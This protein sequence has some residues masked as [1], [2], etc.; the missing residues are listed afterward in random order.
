M[1]FINYK[2][3]IPVCV[4]IGVAVLV[5]VLLMRNQD[6]VAAN[7]EASF[8][9]EIS[10]TEETTPT[11]ETISAVGSDNPLE[12]DKYDPVNELVITYLNALADGDVDTIASITNNM[13]DI[14]R[15]RIAELGKC[16]EAFPEYNVFTKIGPVEGSY[17]VYAAARA[18]F[19]KVDVLVPGIYCFYVCV[20]EAGNY[21][22]N[23]GTLTEEEQIYIDA[24]NA[25]E[26]VVNLMQAIDTEY[27][28]LLEEN[29]QVRKY[30]EVMQNE[31]RGAVGTALASQSS[32][33]AE[34]TETGED[35]TVLKAE[36]QA[37][38]TD[39][40]NVRSSDSETADKLGS[41]VK[42]TTIDVIEIRVNGWAK[43][44]YEGKEAYIK[45]DYLQV[46]EEPAEASESG[47]TA[48]GTAVAKETVN[49]RAEA[50]TTA[51]RMGQIYQGTK[52][53]WVEDL[54]NGWSK[55]IYE[56]KV[57]YIKSE[58]LKKD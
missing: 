55:I 12:A 48:K 1:K 24:V 2:V 27:K 17:I 13:T 49:V 40:I 20:D 19:P 46:I 26:A 33:T 21:Y 51:N 56:G 44:I 52:V 7:E 42:G 31:I 35:P 47:I 43:F 10:E 5:A 36:C 34:T 53:E 54:D 16:I 18:Q 41:V 15:I 6:A 23:E 38:T 22:F 3:L 45:S 58:F 28:K 37:I 11:E 4:V 50:S 32:E 25:D 8:V 57:G 29:E 39:T 30:V 9:S 14:E